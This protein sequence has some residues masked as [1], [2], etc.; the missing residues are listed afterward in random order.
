MNYLKKIK[1]NKKELEREDILF[2]ENIKLG[3]LYSPD[4]DKNAPKSNLQRIQ[5]KILI[6]SKVHYNLEKIF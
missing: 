3:R 1:S 4:I 2:Q 5:T 6:L